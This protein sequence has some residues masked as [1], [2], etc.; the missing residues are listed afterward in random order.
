MQTFLSFINANSSVKKKTAD[1]S[2]KRICFSVFPLI[3]PHNSFIF[4]VILLIVIVRAR[5]VTSETLETLIQCIASVNF[6][7][8]I[9]FFALSIQVRARSIAIWNLK[10]ANAFTGIQKSNFIHT[11]AWSVASWITTEEEM[12][13]VNFSFS[14]VLM[15]SCSLPSSFTTVKI[16]NFQVKVPA[17]F[18]FCFDNVAVSEQLAKFLFWKF[19]LCVVTQEV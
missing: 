12:L 13:G 11:S 5:I 16:L 1:R 10:L 6:E 4:K 9:C 2:K 19:H 7:F 14:D 8:L 15:T 3:H 17:V 18:C